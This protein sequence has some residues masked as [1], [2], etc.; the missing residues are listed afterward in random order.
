[1]NEPT[2]YMF[3]WDHINLVQRKVMIG[4]KEGMTKKEWRDHLDKP[5]FRYKGYQY[6]FVEAFVFTEPNNIVH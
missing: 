1:M 4:P 6:Y 3:Y 2:Y 5:D